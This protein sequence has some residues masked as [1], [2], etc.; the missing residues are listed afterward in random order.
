M[1]LSIQNYEILNF[2]QDHIVVSDK[3]VSRIKSPSLLEVLK[4]L[5]DR[6]SITDDELYNLFN[7]HDLNKEEAYSSL[8]ET[9][10]LRVENQSKYFDNVIV[11]HD[12]DDPSGFERMLNSELTTDSLVCPLSELQQQIV[13]NSRQF[14]AIVCNNYNYNTL[15]TLY[16]RI[17]SDAPESAI[18]V[19]YVNGQHYIIGQPFIPVTGSPCHFCTIDRLVSHEMY[20]SSKNTWS[21]LLNFCRER[22]M[23]IPASPL[24]LYQKSLVI[25]VLAQKIK[26]MTGTSD[27]YR[28]QDNIL[29]QTTI[30][31]SNGQIAESTISH[32]SMCDCLRAGT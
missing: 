9:I 32:W 20:K 28:Y 23:P 14:I 6:S 26:L 10:N 1:K 17:A 2:N 31:L 15:K 19:S 3:G 16:F 18:N 29:H 27:S 21:R 5:K 24:N 11:A 8:E 7:E 12:W 4:K 25:G 30:S 13:K 22:Y